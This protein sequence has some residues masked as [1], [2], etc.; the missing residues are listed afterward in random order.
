MGIF[1]QL[2]TS[3]NVKMTKESWS[4]HIWSK[5]DLLNM[6]EHL[7]ALWC[8]QLWIFQFMFIV[9]VIAEQK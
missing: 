2:F 5:P 4:K 1:K 3:N 8:Q 6:S 7:I 9:L